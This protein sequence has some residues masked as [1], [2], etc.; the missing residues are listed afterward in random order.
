M[1]KKTKSKVNQAG[2]YTKPTMRKNLKQVA[3]AVSQ[4]SGLL[5]KHKCLLNNIKQKAEDINNG[6]KEK[7][8]VFKKLG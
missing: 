6:I 5:A 8:K 4:V 1:K 7:S 2:N 3:K